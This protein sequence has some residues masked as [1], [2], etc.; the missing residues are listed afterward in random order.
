MTTATTPTKLQ[1]TIT[2]GDDGMGEDYVRGEPESE[3]FR[4]QYGK[5]V[6]ALFEQAYPDAT[7][8]IDWCRPRDVQ[9]MDVDG[10][11]REDADFLLTEAWE[12]SCG[13]EWLWW[14]GERLLSITVDTT[15]RLA[16][17]VLVS[18]DEGDDEGICEFVESA[19][20]AGL[21]VGDNWHLGVRTDSG[22]MAYPLVAS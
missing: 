10:I 19:L 2:L 7:I 4:L 9:K 8:S 22:A 17:R 20:P 13:G 14:N 5:N 6:E 15:G 16:P 18:G 11:E 1:I 21:T 12:R 3:R